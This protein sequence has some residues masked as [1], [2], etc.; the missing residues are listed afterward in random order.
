[1]KTHFT[2]PSVRWGT[3]PGPP[4]CAGGQ[5][6]VPPLLSGSQVDKETKVRRPSL[7]DPEFFFQTIRRPAPGQLQWPVRAPHEPQG[8]HVAL[9]AH[10]VSLVTHRQGGDGGHSSE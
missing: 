9:G 1:M 10:A 6:R 3:F 7:P 8:L 2:L 5:Q 4:Q